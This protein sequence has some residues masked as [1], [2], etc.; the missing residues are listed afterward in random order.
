MDLEAAER[1]YSF[2]ATILSSYPK[3]MRI[4]G[5]GMDSTPLEQWNSYKS[6]ARSLLRKPPVQRS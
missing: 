2:Y 4:E 5:M 3:L 6:R 1:R